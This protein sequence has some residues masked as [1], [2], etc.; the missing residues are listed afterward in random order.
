[1]KTATPPTSISP[2][3]KRRESTSMTLDEIRMRMLVNSM[4]I[5]IEKQR[6]QSIIS[7]GY[8]PSGA[9]IAATFSRLDSLLKYATL[10][11]TTFR[12]TKKAVSF[13]KSL[14]NKS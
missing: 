6:L 7:P 14:R 10:A 5:H 9:T 11:A 13:F 1:M 3:S 8:S 12:L 4:K 2:A